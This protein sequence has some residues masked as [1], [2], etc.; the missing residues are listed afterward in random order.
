MSRL[1]LAVFWRFSPSEGN[2]PSLI[3]QFILLMELQQHGT[4]SVIIVCSEWFF[5]FTIFKVYWICYNIASAWCF[6]FWSQGVWDLCS[7]TRDWTCNP[8]IGRWSL[9][10]WSTGEVPS[11]ILNETKLCLSLGM[12]LFWRAEPLPLTQQDFSLGPRAA[13]VFQEITK[14]P[15][16]IWDLEMS[17]ACIWE[18]WAGSRWRITAG[19]P[20]VHVGPYPTN[21]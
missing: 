5:F 3:S 17:S 4:L 1:Q 8:C 13:P 15:L 20:W 9:N 10:H 2:H 16:P 11:M 19:R 6:V 21:Q 18:P 12:I 7:L 14:Q